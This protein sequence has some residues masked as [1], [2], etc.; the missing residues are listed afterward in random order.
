M[1]ATDYGHGRAA[2]VD[3]MNATAK[4][5]GLAHT[6]FA[7]FDGLP[8][9]TQTSAYSTPADLI[10]LAKAAMG[11]AVFRAIVAQR[12]Y[13]LAAAAHR[14][15]Y[16]WQTT[17]LLLGSYAGAD[18]IKTGFTA[19]AG[20]CLLFEATDGTT[21]LVG[22]VLHSTATD[23]D[24]RFTDATTLL[25]WGYGGRLRGRVWE[26]SPDRVNSRNGYRPLDRLGS[27]QPYA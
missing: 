20:Y 13:H 21:A 4:S 17:N 8:W 15:T 14:H 11:L 1:L 16:S 23:P 19:A 25:N 2:Y 27:S 7:N 9:P 18:G 22:V 3:Q 10:R 5:L 24:A 26:V 6:H 12:S